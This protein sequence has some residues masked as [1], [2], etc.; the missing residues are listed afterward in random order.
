[1]REIRS[2]WKIRLQ[3]IGEALYGARWITALARDLGV[4]S[5]TVQR[6]AAGDHPLPSE[7]LLKLAEL[8]RDRAWRLEHGAEAL[9]AAY[10][11]HRGLP[12]LGTD[13]RRLSSPR[14]P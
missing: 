4:S 9:V 12:P 11:E 13:W 10:R 5:R 8:G 2:H 6:W 3:S 1:M 14:D 7:T